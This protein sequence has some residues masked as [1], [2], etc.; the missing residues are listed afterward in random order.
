LLAAIGVTGA[1]AAVALY[2][3]AALDLIL[4]ALLLI[5]WRPVLVGLLQL[6]SMAIFTLLATGL[7]GEYWLHPFAPI[8]KNIPIAAAILIMIAL[9]AQ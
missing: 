6:A 3:G 5:G 1:P 4:G 8:L 9:E 2:G 7:G